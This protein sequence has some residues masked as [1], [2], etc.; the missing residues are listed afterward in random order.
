MSGL[1]VADVS[2]AMWPDE[3]N[4]SKAHTLYNWQSCS[5]RC[6]FRL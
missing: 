4:V 3:I 1:P 6:R 2:E 5:E